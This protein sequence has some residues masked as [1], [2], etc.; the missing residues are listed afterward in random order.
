[1]YSRH[2]HGNQALNDVDLSASKLQ[3]CALTQFK[4][5]PISVITIAQQCGLQS[6][7]IMQITVC[8]QT[9]ICAA[10]KYRTNLISAVDNGINVPL[11]PIHDAKPRIQ[12]S[13]IVAIVVTGAGVRIGA[14]TS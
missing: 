6:S 8:K 5:P 13:F 11:C 14:T 4:N 7:L 2:M 10:N 9:Q 1:M 3:K 12:L